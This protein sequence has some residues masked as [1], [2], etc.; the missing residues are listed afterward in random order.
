MDCHSD[1]VLNVIESRR[2]GT[3]EISNMTDALFN[4][5]NLPMR[6]TTDVWTLMYSYSKGYVILMRQQIEVEDPLEG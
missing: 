6:Y 3:K 5:N 4:N 1:D 2:K